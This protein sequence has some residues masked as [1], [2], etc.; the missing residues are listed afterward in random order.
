MFFSQIHL[1]IKCASDPEIKLPVVIL[2][3]FGALMQPPAPSSFGFEAYRNPN[4]LAWST[5]PQQ[6]AFQPVDS[7]P[8]Y[9]TYAMYPTVTDIDKYKTAL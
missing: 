4:Q 7:P 6:A 5:T 8:S 9:G 1:D 3:E 2:P